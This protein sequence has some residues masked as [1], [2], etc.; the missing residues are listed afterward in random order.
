MD[1]KDAVGQG[2]DRA[3]RG[4]TKLNLFPF[5]LPTHSLITALHKTS[6]FLLSSTEADDTMEEVSGISSRTA[7]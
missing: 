2:K 5:S 7:G 3:V 1:S 6:C 4:R